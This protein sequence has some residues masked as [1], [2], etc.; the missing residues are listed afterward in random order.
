MVIWKQTNTG[1]S[2]TVTISHDGLIYFSSG[3]DGNLYVVRAKDGKLM[4]KISS[5]HKD[6]GYP[7]ASFANGGPIIDPDSN[8]LYISDGHFANCYQINYLD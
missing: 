4:S 5:P 1:G 3:G 8:Q 6:H 2:V 7:M